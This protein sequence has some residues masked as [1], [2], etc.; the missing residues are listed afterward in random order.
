MIK[1]TG[2]AFEDK[3][4]NIIDS[5]VKSNNFIV[6]EPNVRVRRKPKYYS[7]DRN[8]DIVFDVSVEKYLGNPDGSEEMPPSLIIVIECKDYK[9]NIPV[10]DIEEF[11]SKLQQIGADMTKGIMITNTAFFQKSALNYANANGISLARILPNDQVKYFMYYSTYDTASHL[12]SANKIIINAL[13]KK[14]YISD[15]GSDFFSLTG[16][17]T[18]E[19]LVCRL[20][21]LPY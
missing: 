21:N 4:F 17:K 8:S 12:E 14:D 20:L 3:V 16:E 13:S 9:N 6:S 2:L 10:D 19:K 7:R 5:L 18:L 1:N 15:D 11:H